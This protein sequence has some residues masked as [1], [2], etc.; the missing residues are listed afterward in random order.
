MRRHGYIDEQLADVDL[1]RGLG[2][3]SL[4]A[5][6][7][8]TTRVDRGVGSVL[9]EQGRPGTELIVLL[10][11]TVAVHM[12]DRE[13]ATRGP[14][15]FLGEISLLRTGVQTAT[16]RVTT[17]VVAAV[18]SKPDFWSLLSAVPGMTDVL[19]ATMARRLDEDHGAPG[20]R[21]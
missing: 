1:F 19:H 13:V 10:N 21:S 16:A 8:L 18:V 6:T 9:T 11:G 7:A 5:V 17:P 12:C 2:K 14:G 4:R 15:E 20:R 3:P